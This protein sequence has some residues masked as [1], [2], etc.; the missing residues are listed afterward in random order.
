ME[1]RCGCDM[2]YGCRGRRWD[3]KL[4]RALFPP[5]DADFILVV[6]VHG[7]SKEDRLIWHFDNRGR[8]MVRTAYQLALSLDEGENSKQWTGSPSRLEVHWTTRVQP[9]VQIF[10][11]RLCQHVLPTTA[12]L[13][14]QDRFWAL[15]LI[16][17]SVVSQ[18]QGGVED[19]LRLMR[20]QLGKDEFSLLLII[21]WLL[22]IAASTF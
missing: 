18:F 4:V 2:S 9:K 14:R 17:W 13:L 5:H 21:C 8:F 11:W 22:W 7:P 3:T 15:A 20:L 6:P 10:A 12:N 1:K 19:W 16:P